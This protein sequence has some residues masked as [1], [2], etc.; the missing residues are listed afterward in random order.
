MNGARTVAVMQP[1]FFPYAGYYRLLA[2]ADIFVIFDCVQ[3]P[4]AGRVHRCEVPGPAGATEWLTLPLAHQP[5]HVLIGNL[6]FSAGARQEF[7]RR[8]GRLSWIGKSAGPAAGPIR[9]YLAEPLGTVVDYLERGLRLVC[10]LLGFNPVILRSSSFDL[11][12]RWRGQQRVIAA[13]QAAGATHYVNASGG[14]SLYDRAG[15]NEAGIELGFLTPYD[16]L[17]KHMLF[18]LTQQ[19]PAVIAADIRRTAIVETL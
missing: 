10:S 19:D 5:L 4:R 13:A 12:P 16:G 6:A 11:D 1:Y 17:F 8:M 3:F 9:A 2:C 14:R 18:D 15:F 7:D